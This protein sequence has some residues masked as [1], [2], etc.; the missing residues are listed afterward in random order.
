[1]AD[2]A[3]LHGIYNGRNLDILRVR[4]KTRLRVNE[5]QYERIGIVAIKV[6]IPS[7]YRKPRFTKRSQDDICKEAISR[8][9]DVLVDFD[10]NGGGYTAGLARIVDVEMRRKLVLSV[11]VVYVIP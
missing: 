9:A 3:I 6:G 11:D 5:G 10:E 4:G 2:N 7:R 1:M 8:G